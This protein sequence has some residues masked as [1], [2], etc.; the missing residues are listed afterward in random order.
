LI[1]A[2]NY[3]GFKEPKRGE[4][5][6]RRTEARQVR[7][8]TAIM[9]IQVVQ[10]L[11]LFPAQ[12]KECGLFYVVE[13]KVWKNGRLEAGLKTLGLTV[14]FSM[15]AW[16]CISDKQIDWHALFWAGW[17][18]LCWVWGVTKWFSSAG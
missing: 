8:L 3:R 10:A 17:V 6:S 4:V 11:V 7:N 9:D 18:A 16:L 14:L 1:S 15:A 13:R 5:F 2:P 12:L